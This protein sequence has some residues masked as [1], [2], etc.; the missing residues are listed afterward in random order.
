[1]NAGPRRLLLSRPRLPFGGLGAS[2][3]AAALIA[4][5]GLSAVTFLQAPRRFFYDAGVYWVIGG[6]FFKNGHFSLLN[7]ANPLRG[8]FLPLVDHLIQDVTHALRVR[9]SSGAKVVNI[10]VFTLIATVLVPR[11]AELTW[12]QRRWL[13]GRRVT[14]AAVMA[15]LWGGFLAFPLSD[16]PAVAVFLVALIAAAEPTPLRM[17]GAGAACGLAIDMRPAY[18]LLPLSLVLIVAAQWWHERA[19]WSTHRLRHVAAIGC[20]VLGFAVISAPETLAMHHNYGYWE[21]LPGSH[22]GL[23]QLQYN[24]GLQL[25]LYDTFVGHGRQPPQMN[26]VDPSGTALSK[27]AGPVTSATQYLSLVFS[28]TGT[29]LGVF[30]RHVVNGLDQRYN[31]PYVEAVGP[32][33]PLRILSLGFVFLMLLRLAWPAARAHLAPTRWRFPLAIALVGLSALP[34]AMETRYMLPIA[35]LSYLVVL[36]P[37]WAPA[38]RTLRTPRHRYQALAVGALAVAVFLLAVVPVIEATTRQLH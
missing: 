29:M 13:L 7:Y 38:L 33:L 17:L 26:Y 12:P 22:T 11:L 37:G 14:L 30:Y 35:I 34:S 20:A 4:F 28:H 24:D 32:D 23:A 31:T 2:V 21:L 27:S 5:V 9:D 3:P 6:T 1:M 25:Q 8:Y 16:M 19:A 18:L 15:M 10:A 36:T